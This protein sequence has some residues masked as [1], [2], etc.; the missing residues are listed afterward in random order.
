MIFTDII[1]VSEARSS[2]SYYLLKNGKTVGSDSLYVYDNAYDNLTEN[3]IRFRDK[4]TDKV[5]FFNK[6]GKIVIPALY[7]DARSFHNGLALVIYNGKRECLGGK[8]YNPKEPCEDWFW[9]GISALIDT[10]NKIVADSINIDEIDNLNWYTFKITN[11]KPDTTLYTIF[12]AKDSGFC[13]FL[14]Y[15]KEFNYWF[16]KTYLT[17]PAKNIATHCYTETTVE[18]K[19][20]GKFRAYYLKAAFLKQYQ[21]LLIKKMQTIKAGTTETN[22]FNEELNNYIYTDKYFTR[23]YDSNGQSHK[24]PCFNVVTTYY[25]KAR[26][27][28]YQDQFIFIRTDSGYM[29]IEIALNV[30]LNN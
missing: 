16:Y 20:N 2:K 5:G 22:I 27:F 15:K 6:K 21:N 12:K 18:D 28:D 30:G 1:A 11:S 9:H 19:P 29:L 13:S 24:H 8:T 25:S 17:D 26:K 14:N 7:N 10:N 4:K 23:F 3:K